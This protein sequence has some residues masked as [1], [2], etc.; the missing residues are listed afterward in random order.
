M[1]EVLTVVALAIVAV[2]CGAGGFWCGHIVGEI[3]GRRE[4]GR[5][6]GR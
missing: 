5:G 3:K 2:A 6:S 4:V 1:D